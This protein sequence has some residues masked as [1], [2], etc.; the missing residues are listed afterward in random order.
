MTGTGGARTGVRYVVL[1]V[2][3]SMGYRLE[4]RPTPLERGKVEDRHWHDGEAVD[5]RGRLLSLRRARR[6]CVRRHG[7]RDRD[8]RRR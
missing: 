1:D 3:P 5:F 8:G 4:G 7:R 6:G 2:S